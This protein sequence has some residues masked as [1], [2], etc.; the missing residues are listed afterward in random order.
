MQVLRAMHV[1]VCVVKRVSIWHFRAG[2]LG[3]VS[4]AKSATVCKQHGRDSC[5]AGRVR[6]L[7][8]YPTVTTGAKPQEADRRISTDSK[9]TGAKV[10]SERVGAVSAPDHAL[11]CQP[12]WVVLRAWLLWVT[13]GI[14]LRMPCPR[15]VLDSLAQGLCRLMEGGDCDL[16]RV[17]VSA[18]EGVHWCNGRVS[19][20][21]YKK[22]P[23]CQINAATGRSWA[24][25]SWRCPFS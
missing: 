7:I 1:C 18:I 9:A 17:V 25:F 5:N 23:R 12:R 3:N 11:W 19:N 6:E 4:A 2:P 24:P 8:G 10:L 21:L 13:S 15:L 14:A 16:W 22:Y 20:L